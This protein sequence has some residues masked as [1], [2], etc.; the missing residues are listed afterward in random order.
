MRRNK[1]VTNIQTEPKIAE[2]GAASA[3]I[4]NAMVCSHCGS[5]DVRESTGRRAADLLPANFGKT[6]YRCRVCRQR[7]HVK[8]IKTT[9]D[10]TGLSVAARKRKPQRNPDPFW[11]R[12]NTK[13]QLNQAV[14]V[15]GSIVA[16]AVFLY[17][18]V[19]SVA[20]D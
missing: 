14:I 2:S 1:T 20:V 18:L 19:H 11:K 17:T 6:P 13:R 10:G 15:G 5:A 7:F 9:I 8:A 12:P 16:F 3:K 4:P